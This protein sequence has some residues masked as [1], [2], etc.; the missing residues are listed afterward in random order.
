MPTATDESALRAWDREATERVR[1]EPE[2]MSTTADFGCSFPIVEA[3]PAKK[4]VL[5]VAVAVRSCLARDSAA[6][7]QEY[8]LC[9]M[10]Y[11][12]VVNFTLT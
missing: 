12:L 1:G 11:R 8:V 3:P 9:E 10:K 7:L 6:V 5:G 2:N 4:A